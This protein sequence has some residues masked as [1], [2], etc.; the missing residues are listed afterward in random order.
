M[1]KITNILLIIVIVIV[2]ITCKKTPEIPSGSTKVVIGET[3]ADSISYNTLQLSSTISS[4]GGY[5]ITQHGHCWSTEQ[6]PTISDSITSLGKLIQPKTYT[7]ELTNLTN[8]TTYYVRSY[9]THGNSTVYGSEQHIRTL[10]TGKPIVETTQVSDVTLYTAVLGGIAQADSGL[11][12]IAKGICWDTDNIFT[13]TNCIDTTIVGNG[14]GSFISEITGLNEGVTY[15]ATAYATNEEGTSYGEILQFITLELT[16]PTVITTEVTNITPYTATG[17]GNVTSNGNGTVSA[18]GVCW[19]TSG[20]PTFENNLGHTEDGTGIGQFNSQIIGIN[21]GTTYYIVAYATNEKGTG[22]GEIV[23]F[24]T[25]PVTL[26]IITT[27]EISEITTTSAI[28]GGNVTS[29]GTVSVRGV[30]WN[31]IGNPTLENNIGSSI[32]GDGTGDFTSIITGLN[33]NT[34]YYVRA[35]AI[36]SAGT[37]YGDVI[38]FTTLQQNQC[39]QMIVNY[40]G[41]IYNTVFIGEQCWLK[42]NLNIGVRINV[43]QDMT[44]NQTIE[45]YCYDDNENNCEIY[46]G[47]YQWDEIMQYISTEGSQG[48]CPYGWHIPTD[49]EWCE[50]ATFIDSS[51]DCNYTSL[52]GTTV[53]YQ[54]KSTNDWDNNG[55]GNDVYNFT[56]LPAGYRWS[57][58]YGNLKRSTIFSTSSEF[59]LSHIWTWGLTYNHDEIGHYNVD[60][61]SYGISVRCVKN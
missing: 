40:G 8:N 52:I 58:G 46:G 50:L 22:Y 48:I 25:I 3:I 42:E 19:N 5:E 34:A 10:K 2:A 15:Y 41:Q 28:C 13:I 18:Y 47:L 6:V 31:T 33:E 21:E 16:L 17:G 26:P 39:G 54:L 38:E 14:L 35:Y 23:Q 24:S 45:K 20:N 59:D 9:I 7:S 51:V 53:G 29:N 61:K 12:V 56:A 1:K 57:I 60:N 27:M 44:D 11:T 55:N 30:C 32:N 43:S 49:D 37:G 4:T 36:N